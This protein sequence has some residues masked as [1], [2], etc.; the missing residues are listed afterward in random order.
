M[1]TCVTARDDEDPMHP[2]ARL[3]VDVPDFPQAGHPVP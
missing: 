2:L 1:M 3:I